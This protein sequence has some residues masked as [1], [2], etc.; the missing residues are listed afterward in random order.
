MPLNKEN[1]GYIIKDL[2]HRGIVLD[3]FQDEIVDHVCSAVEAELEKGTR[4][5]DAYHKVLKTF[6][7]DTELR[8]LQRQV[9]YSETKT[10]TIMLRN[11]VKV[12]MR[13]LSRQKFYSFVNIS[14]L[15]LG[16]ASCLLIVLFIRHELSYDRHHLNADKIYRVN[17]EIK[18]ADTHYR[19]AVAPAPLAEAVLHEYPEVENAVRFN[20]YGT[21]LVKTENAAESFREHNVV[22]ADSTLFEIFT[23]RVFKGNPGN[24]L[25]EPTSVAISRSIAEKYFNNADPLGQILVL[26]GRNKNV[27]A[28]FEDMPSTGH[29]RF[30]IVISMAGLQDAKS[31][32][33]LSN[34]YNTYLL[35]KP[36][37]DIAAFEAKLPDFVRRHAGPQAA[38]ALGGDFTMEKF[39]AAGNKLEYTLMPLA[40]IHLNSDLTAELGVNSDVTYVY[41]FGAVAIF[42]LGI[43]CINFMNLSTARS[44][45][46]A[47]EVGLRKVMGSMRYHLI[48]QFLTESVILSIFSFMLAIGIAWVGLPYF[49]ALS[50]MQ[51]SLP[52]QTPAF[53]YSLATGAVVVGLL[54]G[55]YPSLFLSAFEPVKVLKGKLALGSKS[56]VV[57]G[58]LVVFQ[59]A[60]S[61]FLIIGTFTVTSQL[62]FIQN[63]KIGF[64]KDQVIMVSDMYAL[65]NQS[66]SY[67]DQVLQDPSITSGTITGYIPVSGGWRSDKTFWRQGTEPTEETMVGMQQWWVDYDYLK[68]MDMKIVEGREFSRDFPSDSSAVVLN[69]TAVRYFHFEGNPIGQKIQ[70]FSENNSDGTVNATSAQLHTVI[71]IVEDFHFESLKQNITPLGFHLGRSRGYALFR[72][73][74]ANTENVIRTLESTWKKLATGQ[75]FQYSFLDESFGRMYASEERLGKI[76]ASFA[77]LAIVIACLGLFALTAFTSEQRTREIGIRKVLGA[78]VS[79]IV[80]LLSKEFG[81][82]IAIAFL[83]ATPVAWFA[84]DWWLESYTYKVELGIAVFLAAGLAA[85]LVAWLTMSYQSI[86]AA[87]SNPVNALRSE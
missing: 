69:Q 68:T 40:D 82:W 84:V 9:I 17:C 13:N 24:A 54:A 61:I 79:S 81:K 14:G 10:P 7:R 37:T 31:V 5:L 45:N 76:F 12:A 29:F 27:T 78:S 1:I 85:F 64:N 87:C 36:G 18:F 77:G 15:A 3:D 49:N 59:F 34:N 42:I 60:I 80:L 19:L 67:K 47:K 39:Y 41:L 53:Y 73:E 57:R 63:K 52:F 26:D 50:N 16:I 58:T 4:F 56:G 51:L 32:N 33:F 71:G 43:A 35:F 2:H 21:Y 74:A 75:P 8:E 86:K 66:E 70:S 23:V 65:G 62:T 25:K 72:F 11:Y 28:V 6:G 83:L 30:D 44:A 20:G 22:F 48:R 46:R 38:A 55:L